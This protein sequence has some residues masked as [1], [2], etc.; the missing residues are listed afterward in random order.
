MQIERQFFRLA[1][2][3]DIVI[4]MFV[5]HCRAGRRGKLLTQNRAYHL[6]K[7]RYSGLKGDKQCDDCFWAR[8]PR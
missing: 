7:S 6:P 5:S 2:K 3:V 4:V 1:H 8:L